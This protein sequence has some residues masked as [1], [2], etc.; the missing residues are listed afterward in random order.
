M[1]NVPQTL[2]PA[3][4]LLGAVVRKFRTTAEESSVVGSVIRK[5]RITE[6]K[7]AAAVKKRKKKNA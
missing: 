1:R 3:E 2:Q 6:E 7:K 4:M 5:F